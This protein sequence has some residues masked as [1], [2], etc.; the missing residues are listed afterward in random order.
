MPPPVGCRAFHKFVEIQ[1]FPTMD[2]TTIDE[3]ISQYPTD[4]QTKLNTLRETIRKAAPR[5][6]ETIKYAIPTFVQNGNLVHFAA[7][8]KHIG[9]YP[10]PSGIIA[11]EKELAPYH[12][13]KGARSVPIRYPTTFSSYSKNCAVSDKRK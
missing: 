1:T 6:T 4:L 8:K 9:F 11:F 10:A 5:A 12:T 7:M 2:I 13:S 3:Y